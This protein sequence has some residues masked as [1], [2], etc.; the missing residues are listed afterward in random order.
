M[1]PG[2]ESL[3]P[4][5]YLQE[6]GP[7]MGPASCPRRTGAFS[8]LAETS[9]WGTMARARTHDL[10]FGDLE[11]TVR[12][13]EE[14][15]PESFETELDRRLKKIRDD[16]AGS[17]ITAA[18]L[19]SAR[20]TRHEGAGSFPQGFAVLASIQSAPAA[21]ARI[22]V[23]DL[24]RFGLRVVN[25][26]IHHPGFGPYRMLDCAEI[27]G[28]GREGTIF[29]FIEAVR[30]GETDWADHRFAWLVRNLDKEQV[31]DLLLSSGLE[32]VTASL[33]KAGSV[34]DAAALLQ[35]VGWE[36]APILLRPVVR[37]QAGGHGGMREYDQCRD[38]VARKD[39][40]RIARR[41]YPGQPAWGERD[42][43]A[44][45]REAVSWA[46][47]DPGGRAERIAALL[48][49][50]VSLEDAGDLL[51]VGA[52]LLFLQEALRVSDDAHL[53][54]QTQARVEFFSGVLAM[55]QVLHLGTPGQRI[56][57]LLL[58]GWTPTIRMLR[59]ETGPAGC[60]AWLDRL[61]RVREPEPGYDAGADSS[62]W[63]N[64][65][66]GGRPDELLPFLSGLMNGGRQANGLELSL[67]RGAVRLEMLGGLSLK[68]AAR[69]AE[70]YRSCRTP[71]RWI[72]LWAGGLGLA[73]WPAGTRNPGL[74]V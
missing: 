1:E 74:Q 10:D 64:M 14:T 58:S 29:A 34:V 60:G 13:I 55:R 61:A 45:F 33:Q 63:E 56:L 31:V 32:G 65:M 19:A 51:A 42:P 23:A 40:L 35:G 12:W 57:G 17:L 15:P 44:F 3:L 4:S 73:Q 28:D 71:H 20:S 8:G 37:H 25:R 7:V 27:P 47:S 5:Q 49:T 16:G 39:L 26:E 43:D 66:T 72:L 9:G 53:P 52:A 48:E 69:A 41:R 68:V 46:E 54:A 59:L 70:A 6:A 67:L 2:F 24:L 11:K 30:A 38:L 62:G 18:A 21:D 36:R 50:G 22:P